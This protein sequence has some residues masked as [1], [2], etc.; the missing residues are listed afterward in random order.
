MQISCVL[1]KESWHPVRKL[2]KHPLSLSREA[3]W[4]N[5]NGTILRC[6]MRNCGN[7]DASASPWLSPSCLS[8]LS[9]IWKRLSSG[10]LWQRKRE[11]AAPL[12]N[13]GKKLN[14]TQSES[15]RMV[16]RRNS[17]KVNYITESI[18]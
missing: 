17:F 15:S 10:L 7:T 13:G 3:N 4:S 12:I 6:F 1:G 5:I 8:A 18:H 2:Y 11:D 9:P 14:D 16:H